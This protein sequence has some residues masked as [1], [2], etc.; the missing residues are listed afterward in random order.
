V[1][2]LAAIRARPRLFLAAGLALAVFCLLQPSGLPRQTCGILG[3]DAGVAVYLGAVLVMMRRADIEGVRRRAALHDE[4][5]NLIL[6]LT[7]AAAGISV[8]AIGYELHDA[9]GLPAAEAG[10]RVALA[11]VTVVMS[12]SFTHVNYALHYAHAYYGGRKAGGLMFPGDAPPDY[13]DFLY[14]AF[15]VGMTCQV[16]DVQVAGRGLR[17]LTLVHG[18]LAFFFN[19]AILALAINLVAGLF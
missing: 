15:V 13:F 7:I 9:K 14:Y 12:W 17:R 6:S 1:S 2:A 4:G 5:R 11:I 3:W 18:V 19:T 16:S 10:W 8:L